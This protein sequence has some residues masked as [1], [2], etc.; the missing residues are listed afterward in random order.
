MSKE[1]FQKRDAERQLTEVASWFVAKVLKSY[2]ISDEN[3][4]QFWSALFGGEQ[5]LMQI[6][7]TLTRHA[8]FE[9]APPPLLNFGIEHDKLCGTRVSAT[10]VQ[11]LM[12]LG[13]LAT[14]LNE[15]KP[16]TNEEGNLILSP[17]EQWF[18]NYVF[19]MEEY[20]KQFGIPNQ[21]DTCLGAFGEDGKEVCDCIGD[22][23]MGWAFDKKIEH[24]LDGGLTIYQDTSVD[25]QAFNKIREFFLSRKLNFDGAAL[26]FAKE[27]SRFQLMVPTKGEEKGNPHFVQF[28]RQLCNELSEQAL[29][30]ELVDLRFCDVFWSTR[31]VYA[32]NRKHKLPTSELSPLPTV[33]DIDQ[34]LQELR[35][36]IGLNG[37]KREVF[38]LVNLIKV[39]KL[40]AAQGL[41][42][43]PISLHLVFTGNPGT[44]KTT[45]A[46]LIGRIYAALGLISKGHVVEV[47]RSGLVAGYVGQTALKVQEA[48]Q[49]AL[50]GILFVDEAYSLV[51]ENDIFGQEAIDTLL[52]FMEDHRNEMVVIVAGYPKLM[53]KF[54]ESNPGLKSRFARVIPF[55]DYSVDDLASI[56]ARMCESGGYIYDAEF[57][58]ALREALGERTQS[59]N[60]S[61]ANARGA[62]N[63]FETLLLVHANRMA[64]IETPS[65][66]DLVRFTS[67][68][69]MKVEIGGVS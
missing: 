49:R 33:G 63:L 66:D 42:A 47:D 50:G 4:I 27:N 61:F 54:L 22:V 67:D 26:K 43:T 59:E 53:D 34:T 18:Q 10:F 14:L 38:S 36:M 6:S 69:M 12:V 65:K 31:V 30:G 32:D 35:D 24:A 40:R 39:Q 23:C 25:D 41:K 51:K 2:P 3:R 62:R 52:K 60:Q 5:P 64:S 16:R 13:L 17:A 28:W 45:V 46:R 15:Q 57:E 37:V 11:F 44:G 7:E 21:V 58:K 20:F 56:F 55:E 29:A 1:E 48:G 68:D 8:E 9:S 19:S